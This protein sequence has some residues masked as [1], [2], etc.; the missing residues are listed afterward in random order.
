MLAGGGGENGSARN[1]GTILRAQG[2]WQFLVGNETVESQLGSG[3][4]N[5]PEKEQQ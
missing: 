4:S 5:D 2:S 1:G 3:S